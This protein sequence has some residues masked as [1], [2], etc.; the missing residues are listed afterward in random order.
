M[1]IAARYESIIAE[2]AQCAQSAG[3]NPA[4]IKLVAVSK[5]VGLAE[6]QEA[7]EAGINNFG[8]NRPEELAK[9]KQA[10]PEQTWHFIGNIQSRKIPEIVA[11]ADLIHSLYQLHHVEH[12]E[13]AASALNKVQDVLIE[14]NVSGEASKGGVLSGEVSALLEECFSKPHL[15]VCGFMTMAPLGDLSVA[16]NCFTELAQLAK[17]L[18]Q[19]F[20]EQ[21]TAHEFRELSM[22]MSQDWREAVVTEATMVRLGRAIFE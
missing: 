10:F 5:T 2:M 3:R 9:K 16:K 15:R 13:K 21:N 18:R 8:E 14:V 19:A 4:E 17:R 11:H 6:V 1:S 22:G 12:I 20:S 7:I